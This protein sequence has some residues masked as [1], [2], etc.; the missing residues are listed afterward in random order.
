M[1]AAVLI[2][3]AVPATNV[4]SARVPTLNQVQAAIL[5]R[6]HR[7]EAGTSVRVSDES[8][9][10]IAVPR[11]E[12]EGRRAVAAARCSFRYGEVALADPAARPARWR[13]QRADFYLT[14]SPCEGEGQASDL[15]CYSWTTARPDLAPGAGAL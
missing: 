10:P 12:R 14:G 4:H 2:M 7:T 15:M 11:R 6:G 8:C 9:S 5:A 1:L 3:A 13:R